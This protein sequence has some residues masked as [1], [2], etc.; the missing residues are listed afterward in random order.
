[1]QLHLHVGDSWVM[2][3]ELHF[4]DEGRRTELGGGKKGD[5]RKWGGRGGEEKDGKGGGGGRYIGLG[6][7]NR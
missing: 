4:D 3:R 7:K 6:S 2:P 5:G 1:M